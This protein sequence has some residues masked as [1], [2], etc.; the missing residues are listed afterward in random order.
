MKIL[1]FG[2]YLQPSRNHLHV[3]RFYPPEEFDQL[4]EMALELGFEFVASGP[5]VRSSYKAG[6]YLDF[7]DEKYG[8]S[9]AS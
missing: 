9:G 4:K 3:E 1:T 2:Q 6:E 7:L 5:M 8:T